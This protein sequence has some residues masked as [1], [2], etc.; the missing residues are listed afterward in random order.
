MFT[1]CLLLC[2]L[3]E[4]CNIS[5]ICA[6]LVQRQSYYKANDTELLTNRAPT[7]TYLF[8]VLGRMLIMCVV[9]MNIGFYESGKS[10]MLALL[11]QLPS[12]FCL[13]LSG[14]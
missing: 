14:H 4:K 5:Q 3:V 9:C 6:S 10:N 2:L 7:G 11:F 8:K 13:S 1:L 12:T